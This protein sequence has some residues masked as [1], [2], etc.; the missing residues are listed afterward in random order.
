MNWINGTTETSPKRG[1]IYYVTPGGYI[2]S[3]QQGGRPAIIVSNDIGNKNAPIVEVVYLTSQ[4]KPKTPTHIAVGSAI[5]DSTALCEQITTVDK[6]RLKERIGRATEKELRQINHALAVSLNLKKEEYEHME[7]RISSDIGENVFDIADEK[8][9]KLI[10]CA[11]KLAR[12]KKAEASDSCEFQKEC[13]SETRKEE[14]I[15]NNGYRGFLITECSNCGKQR[16]FYAKEP[17]NVNSCF[18]G[19]DTELVDLKPARVICPKCGGKFK[20]M[21]NITAPEFVTK[22]LSCG[23][24]VTLR[25]NERKTAYLTVEESGT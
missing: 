10:D 19:T 21:T 18:C 16:A 4:L 6:N 24:S 1:D 17:I 20:Y 22:C 9:P 13:P 2:G 14:S 11:F 23:N 7:V 3:E 15:E 5:K 12:E 8:I 25:L